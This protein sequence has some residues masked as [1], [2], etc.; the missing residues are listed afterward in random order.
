MTILLVYHTAA[1][2]GVGSYLLNLAVQFADRGHRVL[3][4][5]PEGKLVSKFEE[6]GIVCRRVRIKDWRLLQSSRELA[7]I[8]R[9]ERVE[10][11][12]AHDHSAGAAAWLA[13][14]RTATPYLL[15]IHCRRPFWQ[16]FVVFYWSPRVV[17][18]SRALRDQL[19][20]RMGLPA[21]RVVE[22]F[23]GIDANRF[24][25]SPAESHTLSDLGLVGN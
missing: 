2:G 5:V 18:M 13:A 23:V 17:A 3:A 9:D 7:A 20:H 8:I 6:R 21:R 24:T 10:A 15:T 22:A 16:R 12:H 19:V 4:A 14:H 25:H 1:T 11:V